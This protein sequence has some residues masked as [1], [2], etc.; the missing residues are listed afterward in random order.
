MIQEEVQE[1]RRAEEEA[2]MNVNCMTMIIILY[3]NR[4]IDCLLLTKL[5]RNGNQPKWFWGMLN[6]IFKGVSCGLLC[7]G[8]N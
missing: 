1:L 6:T 4:N 8:T 3:I 5:K 2:R 7:I